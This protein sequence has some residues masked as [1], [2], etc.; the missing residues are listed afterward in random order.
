MKILQL[1]PYFLPYNGGQER[2]VYNLSK[3]LIEM[4]HEVHVITSNYPKCRRYEIID[5]ITVK[6]YTCLFRPL[7]NP[8]TPGLLTIEKKIKD[9]DVVHTHNEHSFAAM[10]AA[11]FRKKINIPL[12]L[13]CHGQLR[14]GKDLADW[15]ERFYSRTIGKKIL[16]RADSIVA[17]SPSDAKY[18]SSFGVSRDKIHILPNAIDIKTLSVKNNNN[19]DFVERYNLTKPIILFVGPVIRRKGIQY[20]LKAIFTLWKE[21]HKEA[22]FLIVGDGD[23]LEKA[24]SFVTKHKLEKFVRFTGRISQEELIQSYKVADIF[25]LPSLS[26]GLPTTILEAMYLGLPVIA[27]DI[28]G[29]KDH[30]KDAAILI[31]P[32]DEKSLAEAIIKLINNPDLRKKLSRIGRELVVRKYTWKKVAKGYEKLYE[33]LIK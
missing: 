17:L 14:F 13:T 18:I 2:Y 28:P 11:Y 7:R 16:R 22:T 1:V 19:R 4:G 20:L 25:V 5:G 32:R 31:P 3:H 30:F 21:K 33:N 27:T 10:V 9:Y 6:R 15:F 29:V 8:I 26:E 23:Y 24:K 12:I